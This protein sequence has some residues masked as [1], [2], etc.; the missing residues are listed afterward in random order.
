MYRLLKY[1]TNMICIYLYIIYYSIL[2]YTNTRDYIRLI[3]NVSNDVCNCACIYIYLQLHIYIYNCN[4]TYT[5]IRTY[6]YK[7]RERQRADV[8]K[9]PAKTNLQGAN[10]AAR[11]Y[12]QFKTEMPLTYECL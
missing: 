1:D 5:C 9:C 3:I 12:P 11:L 6:V 8:C 2:Y 4:C 7:C 10:M